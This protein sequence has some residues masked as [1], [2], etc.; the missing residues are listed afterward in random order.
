MAKIKF[1]H[2][3]K[4]KELGRTIKANTPVEM[5]LKRADEAVENVKAQTEKFPEYKNFGYER[6]DKEEAK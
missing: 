2:D 5:T 3:Y 6:L 1:S 4:D